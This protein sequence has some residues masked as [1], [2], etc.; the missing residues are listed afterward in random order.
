MDCLEGQ[1]QKIMDK[2]PAWTVLWGS[3]RTILDK[4]PARTVLWGNSKKRWDNNAYFA[5]R[6]NTKLCQVK[7][8]AVN[9]NLAGLCKC[10][11]LGVMCGIGD[12]FGRLGG[13]AESAEKK[14]RRL[15]SSEI[16]EFGENSDGVQ[17][18]PELLTRI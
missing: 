16:A 9:V 8:H 13:T 3:C 11:R 7:I 6:T 1:F 12:G 2:H 17:L 10:N 4:H 18:L 15:A 14:K 5:L